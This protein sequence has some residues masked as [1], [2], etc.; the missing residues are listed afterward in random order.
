MRKIC[1]RILAGG[2]APVLLTASVLAQSPQAEKRSFDCW[3]SRDVPYAEIYFIR[4]IDPKP[5][6]AADEDEVEMLGEIHRRV[7]RGETLDLD[8]ALRTDP[9]L[10]RSGRIWQLEI[11]AYPDEAS[12]EAG[13]PAQLVRAAM[14]RP[15]YRCDVHIAP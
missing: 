14:C 10:I 12:W 5:G 3:I 4:C 15:D 7:H 13:R 6:P 9:S 11:Y 1:A 8:H 2:L